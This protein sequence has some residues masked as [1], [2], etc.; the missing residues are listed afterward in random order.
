MIYFKSIWLQVL[1]F[2]SHIGHAIKWTA[3]C[4]FEF[5]GHL[6]RYTGTADLC[7]FL[8]NR[9]FFWKLLFRDSHVFNII[10]S[11]VRSLSRVS[12]IYLFIYLSIY[13]SIYLRNKFLFCVV[14]RSMNAMSLVQS[15]WPP[16]REQLKNEIYTLFLHRFCSIFVKCWWK[17]CKI[18]GEEK[19]YADVFGH[20]VQQPSSSIDCYVGQSPIAFIRDV[21][22]K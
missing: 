16:N 9:V 7:S 6:L 17:S 18:S 13:L 22:Y 10:G 8:N 11:L 20:Y 3:E 15:K 14:H 1:Y 4:Q 2:A 19:L 5:T 12:F 21:A